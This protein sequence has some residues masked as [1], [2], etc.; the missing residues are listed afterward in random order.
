MKTPAFS[1]RLLMLFTAALFTLTSLTGCDKPA[2]E[3]AKAKPGVTVTI[4][5]V[6]EGATGF[7]AGT[8]MSARTVYVFFDAQCPHCGALWAAAKPLKSQARFVWIPVALLNDAS[9]NQ[10]AALLA[11]GNPV[12][13]MDAHETL[14]TA[15]KGGTPAPEATEAQKAVIAKNTSLFTG[16]GFNSIPTVV[17]LNAQTGKLV[18]Q[19]GSVSTETLAAVL[20]LTLPAAPAPAAPASASL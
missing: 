16:F 10:G 14:L 13:A 2:E 17:A 7:V 11:A 5:A 4:D 1:L 12:E 15:H 20:G 6:A 18:T 9:A 8:A 19:E 3:S